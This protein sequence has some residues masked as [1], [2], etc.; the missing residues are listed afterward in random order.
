MA[1][2][3]FPWVKDCHRV[4]LDELIRRNVYPESIVYMQDGSP[5][6]DSWIRPCS[7]VRI[8][9]T[10]RKNASFVDR[11]VSSRFSDPTR[12]DHVV[13]EIIATDPY[14]KNDA[15]R[16]FAIGYVPSGDFEGKFKFFHQFTGRA[17][18]PDWVFIDKMKA[19]HDKPHQTH[20]Q[21]LAVG[22]LNE[23]VYCKLKRLVESSQSRVQRVGD[24][25][26]R[27]VYQISNPSIE[28]YRGLT[29][30]LWEQKNCASFITYLFEEMITCTNLLNLVV[31]G[32]CKPLKRF[33]CSEEGLSQH[34]DVP[35]G[36]RNATCAEPSTGSKRS[37][38]SSEA[39][40][41]PAKLQ[42][43]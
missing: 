6:L 21:L 2:V 1:L 18:S 4:A 20:L 42:K 14:H 15:K 34:G 30:P 3:D 38:E 33:S 37:A 31:P 43:R 17:I 39:S 23:K 10:V 41:T 11:L 12:M 40:Q 13:A 29:C 35:C 9:S 8:W 7:T 16:H 26:Y 32:Y 19:Q 28:K 36:D 24:K 22:V 25:D 5:K 27:H